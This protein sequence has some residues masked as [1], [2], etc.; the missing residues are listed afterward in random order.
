[1]DYFIYC[2]ESGE[3]SFSEK[4]FFKYFLLTSLTIRKDQRQKIIRT[5]KRKYAHLYKL[6]WPKNIEIKASTLNALDNPRELSSNKNIPESVKKQINGKEYIKEILSSLSRC[7]EFEI[8]YFIVNK[9]GIRSPYFREAS[10]GIAYNFFAGKLLPRIIIEKESTFLI[11]DQ[12]NKETHNKKNFD[13][14]IKSQVLG[15]ILKTEK[16]IDLKIDHSSSNEVYG[17]Q[18]V[19]YFCWAI[20]RK[21]TKKDNSFKNIFWD[22]INRSEHW[23]I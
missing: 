4:S 20:N 14:Y 3:S 17:L 15:A 1:M 23:Y 11:M 21:F 18:A 22:K 6:G 12:R 8:D 13:D 16:N 9:D 2:D 7:C 10:Y 5:L 19:D